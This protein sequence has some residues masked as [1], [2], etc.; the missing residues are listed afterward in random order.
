[1]SDDSRALT[2][3][4][5]TRICDATIALLAQVG[6]AGTTHDAVDRALHRAAGTTREVFPT[7]HDLLQAAAERLALLDGLEA[8]DFRANTAGIAAVL[9]RSLSDERRDRL[10]ARFELYLHAARTPEFKTM[11]WAREMFGAGAEA[12]LRVASVKS[13]QLAAVGLIALI[14]GLLLHSFVAPPLARRDR[15]LLIRRMISGFF[16]GTLPAGAER[17]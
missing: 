4:D 10:L 15:S 7:Q 11:H 16:D 3:R 1:M 5:R 8:A 14:E 6:V 9:D 17:L 2:E 12:H 13:P